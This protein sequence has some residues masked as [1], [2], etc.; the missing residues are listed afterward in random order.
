MHFM[1]LETLKYHTAATEFLAQAEKELELGDLRQAS[2][3]GWGAAATIV[4]AVA[5]QED[6]D[7]R[8]H[9]DLY[10]A[11][12]RIAGILDYDDIYSDFQI[13]GS[14]HTNFYEGW[15]PKEMVQDAMPRVQT[16]VNKIASLLR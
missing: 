5:E 15:Q 1:T 10:A 13:A 6:W 7:H 12:V 9:D 8:S 4:K 3:K 2:E 14:L 16:F 11:V